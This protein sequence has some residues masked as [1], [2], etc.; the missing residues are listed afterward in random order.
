MLCF[1]HHVSYL[2]KPQGKGG[3]GNAFR[4]FWYCFHV[5]SMKYSPFINWVLITFF[6][7]VFNYEFNNYLAALVQLKYNLSYM[8]QYF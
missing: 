1:C 4:F 2:L 6:T 7:L 3:V 5:L 8:V